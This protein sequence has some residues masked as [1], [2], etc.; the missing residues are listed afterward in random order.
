[1]TLD[2]R[3][4][5]TAPPWLRRLRLSLSLLL[6][7]RAALFLAVDALLIVG[8][9]TLVL[10]G[11]SGGD[12][13]PLF[14]VVVMGPFLVLGVPIMADAVA[15]ERR[16]GSLDLALSS[17]GRCY[18]ERR[19]GTLCVLLVAQ[20]AV[21]ELVDWI[22]SRAGF[23]ILQALLHAVVAAA[24]LGACVLFWAVRVRGAGAVVLATYAT[25]L[26]CASRLFSSPVFAYTPGRFFH[27]FALEETR[28][29]LLDVLVLALVTA[30]LYAYARRRLVRPE[31]LL[32]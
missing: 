2:V 18:F 1:M 23:P 8:A 26:A 5:R 16:A 20:G 13:G 32:Q 24:F 29:W 9:L 12:H 10:T 19:V 14:V 11:E 31:T 6:A 25:A 30:V 21:I 15:L 22:V 17:P 3:V 4:R 27:P 28:Q 7:R